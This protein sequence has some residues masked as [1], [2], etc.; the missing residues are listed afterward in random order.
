MSTRTTVV[1][2][3]ENRSSAQQAVAELRQMGFRDDQIGVVSH[4]TD[5]A[6]IEEEKGD[7]VAEGALAGAAA[8]ASVGALWG[9]GIAAGLLPA[10]GP[11]IAGGTLA[12]ILASAATGAAAAGLIGALIGMGLPQE[13]AEFYD[14]EFRSGRT[15]VTVRADERAIEARAV[16]DRFNAY[17][18]YTSR[19]GSTTSAAPEH[20]TVDIPVMRE[21]I[22]GP[23][24]TSSAAPAPAIRP[25]TDPQ[26]SARDL[27]P[28]TQAQ[29]EAERRRSEELH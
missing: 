3:F 23:R 17:D 29:T 18:Y 6:A 4:D 21:D 16:F 1:G 22:A 25:S 28:Q 2:V 13:E 10:I 11:V 12:A 8:G 24:E 20:T 15:V 7:T 14:E 5:I 19:G 9:V 26:G 27:P